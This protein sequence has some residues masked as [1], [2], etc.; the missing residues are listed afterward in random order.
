MWTCIMTSLIELRLGHS[1]AERR[2]CQRIGKLLEAL[3]Q[4]RCSRSFKSQRRRDAQAGCAAGPCQ[5]T[6]RHAAE[7]STDKHSQLSGQS[8]ARRSAARSC[9]CVYTNLA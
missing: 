2:R 8:R 6:R 9:L 7:G 3:T 4:Q 1:T 5:G